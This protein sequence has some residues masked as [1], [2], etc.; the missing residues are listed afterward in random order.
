MIPDGLTAEID[1]S[2]IRLL[3]V[4]NYIKKNG[5]VND[6]EMLHTFNCGVGMNIVVAE[7]DA[8]TVIRHISEFYDC[9]EIGRIRYGEEKVEFVNRLVW[10]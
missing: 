5:G 2:K 7:K 4:F 10:V 1:L 9:Y 6:E 3:P 8:A